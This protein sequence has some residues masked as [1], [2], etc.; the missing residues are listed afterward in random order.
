MKKLLV[1]I[2]LP[3]LISCGG[4][5]TSDNN[6][7]NKGKNNPP[8]NSSGINAVGMDTAHMDTSAGKIKK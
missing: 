2:F 5:D 3:L 7:D 1:S 8:G 4:G 6:G